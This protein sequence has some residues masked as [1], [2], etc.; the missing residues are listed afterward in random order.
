MFGPGA[1]SN[2]VR[3]GFLATSHHNANVLVTFDGDDRA[4][5]LTSVYAWHRASHD[6]TPRI[7][8]YYHDVA[9]RTTDGWR[10]A[11]RQLRIAGSENWD[12]E[13]HP[14]TDAD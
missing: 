7:W 11:E 12:A 3:S 9:V 8:G 5:V 2:D 4:T 14:L 1:E 6:L 10:L 13:W